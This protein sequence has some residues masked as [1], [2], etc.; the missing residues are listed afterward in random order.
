MDQNSYEIQRPTPSPASNEILTN[1]NVCGP[2]YYIKNGIWRQENQGDNPCNICPI[3]QLISRY[4]SELNSNSPDRNNAVSELERR[5]FP[6]IPASGQLTDMCS[7]DIDTWYQAQQDANPNNTIMN[8]IDW[9]HIGT[10]ITSNAS[11]GS[12]NVTISDIDLA[13][14]WYSERYTD[15]VNDTELQRVIS[16][17]NYPGNTEQLRDEISTYTNVSCTPSPG[18]IIMEAIPTKKQPSYPISNCP[19]SSLIMGPDIIIEEQLRSW[20]LYYNRRETTLGGDSISMGSYLLPVDKGFEI[21]VN[22]LLKEK[23][24]TPEHDSKMI[25]NIYKKDSIYDLTNQEILYIKRKLNMLFVPDTEEGIIDCITTHTLIDKSICT[26]GLT[27]QMH[28]ILHVLFSVIGFHFNLEELNEKSSPKHKKKLMFMINEL[29]DII[30]KALQ[31][32]VSISKKMETS[33][34]D[35]KV[36]NNT[37][38]LENLYDHLFSQKKHVFSFDLGLDK[39]TSSDTSDTEFNRTTVLA[40][41]GIAFLKYF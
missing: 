20:E 41:L 31:R 16:T 18:S 22:N 2:N 21:C 29:G 40:M 38:V 6:G 19:E 24:D 3:P 17:L 4:T 26:A 10:V 35:N 5:G 8:N 14:K 30:P 15:H 39:L 23:T 28:I 11:A 1:Y 27:E 34:C 25:E 36:S 33:M 13:S 37:L 9:T 12:D 32:I 7:D